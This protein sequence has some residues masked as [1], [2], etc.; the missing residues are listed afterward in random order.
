MMHISILYFIHP[1]F[2]FIESGILNAHCSPPTSSSGS[3]ASPQPCT[4]R[5]AAMEAMR[6]DN[7]N[8][9]APNE[10][11]TAAYRTGHLENN[12][13]RRDMVRLIH[14]ML[15]QNPEDYDPDDVEMLRQPLPIIKLQ[16]GQA[17]QYKKHIKQVHYTNLKRRITGQAIPRPE[18]QFSRPRAE[19]LLYP[20]LLKTTRAKK[21][22]ERKKD[23]LNSVNLKE[24]DNID[25]IVPLP[26]FNRESMV[27]LMIRRARPDHR[28]PISNDENYKEPEID[29]GQQVRTK[30]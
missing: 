20:E 18:P 9:P 25:E 29:I 5:Q 15:K 3:R 21:S 19:L 2:L 23:L 4:S 7:R 16:R 10:I 1:V 27:P 13:K 30:V 17:M 14:K 8:E 6:N 26:H 22:E 12:F 11:P 24:D 28:E